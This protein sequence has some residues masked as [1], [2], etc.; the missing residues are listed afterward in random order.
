VLF[1]F[2]AQA[3]VA[4]GR[5]VLTRG[6]R[7]LELALADVAAVHAWRLP[8]PS[9]GLSLQLVSG[10]RWRYGLATARPALLAGALAA[11]GV[12]P[13]PQRTVMQA[14]AQA[15]LAMQRS[16]LDHP[17]A[18]FVLLPLALAIP[19][20]HL[21]QQIAF[22]GPLGEYYSY[23]LRA[24]V[25]AFMLWWAAWAIGA[26]LSGALLRAV[27]ETGTFLAALL[28]PGRATQ[29]RRWLER[30]GHMALFLGL[31]AWLLMTASGR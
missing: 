13:A 8:I 16:W 5:L 15:V 27:I 4:N 14:Y 22:G 2:S 23:G 21:H 12:P 18:K 30:L 17:F 10:P 11:A 20:F 1:L 31:P 6:G 29:T 3:S 24:Y 25:T 19:A 26:L 7:R 28:R 9:Y